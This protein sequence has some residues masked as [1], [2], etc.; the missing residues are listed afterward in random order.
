M[1][2]KLSRV[3]VVLLTLRTSVFHVSFY[4][5]LA[6]EAEGRESCSINYKRRHPHRTVAPKHGIF[7]SPNHKHLTQTLLTHEGNFV[8]FPK[9][10]QFQSTFLHHPGTSRWVDDRQKQPSQI[11]YILT[12]KD[13]LQS[14]FLLKLQL[15]YLL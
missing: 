10:I 12:L 5:S 3:H 6:K 15:Q 9:F 2:I 1:L 8:H 7:L 11:N 13:F 14:M 4:K